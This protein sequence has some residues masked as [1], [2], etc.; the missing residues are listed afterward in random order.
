MEFIERDAVE[1]KTIRYLHTYDLILPRPLADWDV[2][3]YWEHERIESMREHLKP[4]MVLFD[5][6]TES[7]WCNLVYATMVGP[8]NMVLIE[9][10]AEFWPNIEATWQQNFGD[11]SPLACYDGL[12]S[13]VT[14]DKRTY[15][16]PWPECADGPLIDRNKYQYIHEHGEGVAQIRL[17]DF[18]DRGPAPDAI[19][20]DVEGAE[21]LVL[22]GA[23]DTLANF[24]PLVWASVHPDLGERDYGVAPEQVHDYM[25]SHG[26]VGTHLGTDHEQHWLYRPT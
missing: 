5:V 20:M 13:D 6:G 15:F 11:V 7:G 21:L 4:G 10:T 2:W 24:R 14:T 8:A 1:W 26:Y 16:L 9:P 25:A 19:T 22:Q 23:S 3:E 17:D 12:C 18:V